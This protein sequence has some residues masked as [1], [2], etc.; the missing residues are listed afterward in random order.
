MAITKDEFFGRPLYMVHVTGWPA[1][2]VRPPEPLQKPVVAPDGAWL[3]LWPTPAADGRHIPPDRGGAVY[4]TGTFSLVNSGNRTL[5]ASKRSWKA[6]L[7]PDGDGEPLAGM[8][9]L[10]LKSMSTTRHRCGRRWPGGCSPGRGSR[11]RGTPT[12]SWR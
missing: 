2:A 11:P 9:K 8:S 6:D 1:G 3:A 4:R 5:W 12:P 7:E 10:N